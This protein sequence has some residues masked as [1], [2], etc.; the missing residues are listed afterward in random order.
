M[1]RYFVMVIVIIK[2]IWYYLL[3]NV[4][5]ISKNPK[6]LVRLYY[7]GVS[8]KRLTFRLPDNSK[9]DVLITF[10]I[11][12]RLVFNLLKKKKPLEVLNAKNTTYIFDANFSSI[13]L[14]NTYIK[15]LTGIDSGGFIIKEDLISFINLWLTIFYLICLTITFVP[16]FVASLFYN[17]M[18]HPALLMQ[19][20]IEIIQLQYLVKKNKI[21]HL[22]YFCI[23]EREANIWAFILMKIGV[24]INKIPSEV[25][26]H[27]WNKII[28]AN[29]L[30]T[31]FGYQ[32]Q[33]VEYYKRTMFI[34]KVT[35]WVPETLFEAPK[36]FLSKGSLGINTEF[37]IGFFSSGNWLRH[38]INDLDLGFNGKA[39]EELLLK[40]LINYCTQNKIK[41]KVFLHPLEK[42]EIY[43]QVV[44]SY[45]ENFINNKTVFFADKNTKSIEGFDTIELGI[46]LHSTLMFERLVLGFKTIIAP[47]GYHEGFVPNSSFSNI[48]SRSSDDII[49]LIEKNINLTSDE[50][51]EQNQ[52][53]DFVYQSPSFST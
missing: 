12:K 21:T 34:D 11:Y 10:R 3:A 22:H 5:A 7:A 47:W 25:P 18:Y 32:K 40:T 16:V 24:Y 50:F 44:N 36:R 41:M 9:S 49:E 43:S 37:K 48:C 46:A 35:S 51:F 52:L 15:N 2:T 30:S 45:Y 13:Y 20:F 31:C 27:F 39:N 6:V 8:N 42:K 33:E 28:I 4:L 14:R 53:S 26:L 29:E 38:H 19:E 1:G 17:K 23:Y